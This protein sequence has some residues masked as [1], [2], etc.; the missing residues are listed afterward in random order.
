LIEEWKN[1]DKDGT[2]EVVISFLKAATPA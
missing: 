1:P 2:V